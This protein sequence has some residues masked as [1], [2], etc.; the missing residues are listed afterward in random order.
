[1]HQNIAIIHKPMA[2]SVDSC[3]MVGLATR[4]S[5]KGSQLKHPNNWG[6]PRTYQEGLHLSFE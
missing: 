6:H 3:Q 5:I 2:K 4:L 1:M